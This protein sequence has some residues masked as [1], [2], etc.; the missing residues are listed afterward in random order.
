MAGYTE[1]DK[2]EVKDGL[3]KPF[4][5]ALVDNVAFLKSSL[6][7]LL[8]ETI[9]NPSFENDLDDSGVPDTWAVTLYQAGVSAIEE[10][11]VAHGARAYKF[12]R[13]SGTGNGGGEIE[14]EAF[15]VISEGEVEIELFYAASAALKSKVEVDFYDAA[16]SLISTVS[17]TIQ[18]KTCF[19]RYV[20]TY[21]APA[22]ARFYKVRCIGGATDVDVAGSCYFDGIRSNFTYYDYADHA[23]AINFTGISISQGSWQTVGTVDLFIPSDCSTFK[24]TL[25]VTESGGSG[26]TIRARFQIGANSSGASNYATGNTVTEELSCTVPN[27]SNGTITTVNIQAYEGVNPATGA[28][29][30]TSNKTS[31]R[32]ANVKIEP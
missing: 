6:D 1:L 17:N 2:L 8:G 28:I 12:T 27:G 20:F 26:G 9:T 5:D 25:A 22:G 10:S 24:M 13:T 21:T 14:N 31:G 23:D 15:S 11:K 30:W 16:R 7:Q 32:E 3:D 19:K 4:L 18:D 29:V